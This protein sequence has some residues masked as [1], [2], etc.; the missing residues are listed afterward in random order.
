ML[1][2]ER[3]SNAL[4]S[5]TFVTRR[6]IRALNKRHL[7]RDRDTDVIAFGYRQPGRPAMLVGDVYIAADV[8]RDSARD[9]RISVREELTRLVVHGALHVAGHD[10]PDRGRT[11]SPMWRRQ[12]RLVRRLVK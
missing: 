12:E 10:H 4:V 3:I 11:A 9:N 7:R 8:A 2:G 6:A 1:R 5:V